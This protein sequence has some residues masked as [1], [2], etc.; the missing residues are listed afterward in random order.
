[1]K[2][3]FIALAT[4]SLF[5]ASNAQ[6][7]SA[8]ENEITL[9]GGEAFEEANLVN[10]ESITADSEEFVSEEAEIIPPTTTEEIFYPAEEVT[11]TR[12]EGELSDNDDGNGD[13]TDNDSGNT[14]SPGFLG[15]KILTTSAGA[16]FAVLTVL[17]M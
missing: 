4:T 14:V 5:L 6:I 8:E 1:M 11:M 15:G 9:N 10:N 3:I 16:F 13:D 7:S 17:I 12:E 2:K